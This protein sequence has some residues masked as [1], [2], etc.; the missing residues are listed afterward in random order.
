MKRSI[1]HAFPL[2][3]F[4]ITG[5]STTALSQSRPSERLS[6]R[7]SGGSKGGCPFFTRPSIESD[8]VVL[9][10]NYH[11]VGSRVCFERT[12]FVCSAGN[13]RDDGSC[14][15]H[16]DWQKRT[17]ERLEGG[18]SGG[19]SAGSG[20]QGRSSNYASRGEGSPDGPSLDDLL[21]QSEQSS[22]RAAAAE[23]RSLMAG[24]QR[25]MQENSQAQGEFDTSVGNPVSNTSTSSWNNFNNQ[26]NAQARE[27]YERKAREAQSR[28]SSPVSRQRQNPPVGGSHCEF[29]DGCR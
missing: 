4:I 11:L 25:A 23:Q 2:L 10:T 12:M 15:S 3:L 14:T 16:R 19:A 21:T 1:A 7:V 20:A 27:L 22:D 6:A 5:S 13:W 28:R 9:R 18:S 24:A 8:G 29:A 26:F 17:V